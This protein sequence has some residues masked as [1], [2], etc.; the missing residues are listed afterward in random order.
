VCVCV[1]EIALLTW[2]D[3]LLPLF[4]RTSLLPTLWEENSKGLGIMAA[5]L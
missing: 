5:P 4:R 1:K 2:G 3:F